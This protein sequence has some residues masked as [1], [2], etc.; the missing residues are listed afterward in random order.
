MVHTGK[1][2]VEVVGTRFNVSTRRSAT[3]VVLSS[4][5]VILNIQQDA[6]HDPEEVMME[7]GELVGIVEHRRAIERKR[8]DPAHY[9]A[10]TENKLVFDHTPLAAITQLIEDNYGIRVVLENPALLKK[11]FTGAAPADALEILLGKLSVVYNLEIIRNGN[12]MILK[13]K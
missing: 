1:V 5:K 11:E 7:P 13:E 9:T 12:E 8:V 6:A 3:K 2:K 4:G 10:W